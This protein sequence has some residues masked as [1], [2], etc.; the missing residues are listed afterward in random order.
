MKRTRFT[1]E[2]A[3]AEWRREMIAV[4][5][6]SC[7]TLDEL[8]GH[9]R[10][11]IERQMCRGLT[12]QEAFAI[13]AQRIGNAGQLKSEFKKI[14]RLSIV[15]E[16]IMIGI[17]SIVIAF[18]LFL[19]AVMIALCLSSWTDRLV[20]PLSSVGSVLVVCGWRYTVPFLPLIAGT[21]KR[22][23]AGLGAMAVGFGV[24]SVFVTVILPH[25][26]VSPDGQLPAV[27][28]WAVF[29]IATS[30]CIGL[31]LLMSEERRAIL[32]QSRFKTPQPANS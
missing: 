3:I 10:E 6:K 11:E 15:W 27:G 20:A 21:G 12:D 14:T 26:V 23:A 17:G 22:W 24:T 16:R 30:T 29:L 2:R 31:G 1:L 13:A 9:L 25:F 19:S 18:G 4:G 32:N 7:P 5:I 28:L 8:E